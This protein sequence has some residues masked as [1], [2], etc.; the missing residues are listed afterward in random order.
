MATYKKVLLLLL[1]TPFISACNTSST[2][3]NHNSAHTLNSSK[4]EKTLAKKKIE[5]YKQVLQND[6]VKQINLSQ[7]KKITDT[8]QNN[9][10]IYFGRPTC[11]YCRKVI[12][13]NEKAITQSP[14]KILYVDT[15]LL[16]SEE[17]KKLV[18]FQVTEVPSFIEVSNHLEFTKVDIEEFERRIHNEQ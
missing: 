12:I 15:D 2:S 8:T 1:L 9:R 4:F 14:I 10:L 3:A 18:D 11:L 17:K 13:E 5:L 6:T 7:I 16:T